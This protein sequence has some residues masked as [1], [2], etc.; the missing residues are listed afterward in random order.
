[1]YYNRFIEAREVFIHHYQKNLVNAFRKFQESG[2][3]E[4]IACCATHGYLPNLNINE[5]SVKAQIEIGIEQYRHHFGAL[6]PK[7]YG[8]L[9]AVSIRGA[10]T[11]CS[12][13]QG[14]NI[15]FV[16]P[17]GSSM[18]T[19]NLNS[20]FMLPFIALAVSLLSD[21]IGS[22]LNRYGA[23]RKVTR[24]IQTIVNITAI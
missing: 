11:V 24:A 16:I 4:I 22:P 8:C 19:R 17:M 23:Q 9:N 2:S 14:L 3:L 10:W 7:G 12:K 13:K 1:M 15:S 21:G 5:S 6:T 20:A 18:Q